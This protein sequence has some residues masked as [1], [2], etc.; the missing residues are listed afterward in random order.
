MQ[1]LKAL[2]SPSGS[3]SH[4]STSAS[5]TVSRVGQVVLSR[6]L[7]MA[8][9]NGGTGKTD[10]KVFTLRNIDTSVMVSCGS[11]NGSLSATKDSPHCWPQSVT[12]HTVVPL[13]G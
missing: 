1:I 9:P 8:V 3:L 6:V 5:Q 12:N 13:P 4:S 2:S 7:L 11:L 10:G